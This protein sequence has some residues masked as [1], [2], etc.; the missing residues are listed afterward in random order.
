[1]ELNYLAIGVLTVTHFALGAIWFGPIFG[2]IWMRIHHGDKKISDVEMQ[3]MMQG[4]WKLMVTELIACGLM[5]IA[6][7]CLVSAIP[8]MPG[9]QIGLMAWV[10]FVLPMSAS[11][12]IW[13]WD[14]REWMLSKIALVTGYRLIAFVAIGY[15]LSVWI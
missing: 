6:I 8:T 14:K 12:V 11:N 5:V 4:M 15:I 1:M 10:G 7:A 13:G 9:W 3:K 2:K